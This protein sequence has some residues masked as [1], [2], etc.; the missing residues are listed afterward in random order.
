MRISI[1]HVSRYTYSEPTRYSILALRLTPPSFQ[2]QRVME[3]RVSAPG[4]DAARPFRDGFGNT[5][6]LAT[7]TEEHSES[8]I[9]AK[10]VI[11]TEDCAGIVRGLAD[12]APR[13]VYRRMT[14]NTAASD[15][16][17]ALIRAA[18]A[19]ADI[20]GM[21]NLM[22]AVREA[23]DYQIGITTAHTTAAEALKD[24][25]GVCQDHAHVFISAART[26]GIAARYV[27]GYFFTGADEPADAN[28]AWAE[29]WLEGLGWVGFDPANRLCPTDRY[30]RLTTG[31]DATSA[32]PIRGT[33]KG[34]ANEVLDVIVEVQ[35]QSSQQQ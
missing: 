2:G 20:R 35:Q 1:G 11:E 25:K 9:I 19:T 18:G 34:I 29:V 21:H 14:A 27:S 7:C 6:H 10:G 28:H 33:R 22:H 26:L 16:I 5:V 30:V 13:H 31:L 8:L 32:A 23:V 12:P 3:W 17:R 24:G 15:D 4:I